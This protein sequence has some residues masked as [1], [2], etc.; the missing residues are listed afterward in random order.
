MSDNH[1]QCTSSETRHAG[2][3]TTPKCQITPRASRPLGLRLVALSSTEHEA[4]FISRDPQ[5]NYSVPRPSSTLFKN[6]ENAHAPLRSLLRKGEELCA[7]QAPAESAA[8]LSQLWVEPLE[9]SVITPTANLTQMLP[10]S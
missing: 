6:E 2:A 9:T 7:A 10:G 1:S 8:S 4:H 3:L 5:K